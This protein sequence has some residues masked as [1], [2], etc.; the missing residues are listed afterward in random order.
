MLIVNQDCLVKMPLLVGMKIW[1]LSIQ[2]ATAELKQQL[3]RHQS[4]DM[5]SSKLPS[6]G[7]RSRAMKVAT[8]CVAAQTPG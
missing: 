7:V 1:R 6:R 8:A 5:V 4:D 2:P 3:A